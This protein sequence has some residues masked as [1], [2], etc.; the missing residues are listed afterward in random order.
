[1]R[2]DRSR[3]V[4]GAF[5][6]RRE[7]DR[8][9]EIAQ[10]EFGIAGEADVDAGQLADLRRIAAQVHDLR[11]GRLERPALFLE[12]DERVHAGVEQHVRIRHG[13][14]CERVGSGERRMIAMNRRRVSGAAVF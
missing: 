12:L 3:L 7:A 2:G 11:A 13:R 14:V 10:A 4:C 1:M 6:T 9:D 8:A 5:R